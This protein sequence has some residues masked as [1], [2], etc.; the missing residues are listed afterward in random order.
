M[1][2]Q[3][4]TKMN[5]LPIDW[6]III[7]FFA[8][9]LTIGLWVSYR[10]SRNTKS[11]FLSGR[12]MPWWLLGISMV[13]TTFS[14][15]T[16]N[17]V[18][19]IVRTNGVS[20][21]WVWWSF[22]LTGMLTVFIYAKLWRKSGVFT[23]LEF[24]ELRYSGKEA[25][26]L[27]VFRALYLGVFFNVI[28]MATVCLA[29]IKIGSVTLGLSPIQTLLVVSLIT[30]IYSSIGGLKGVIITDFF[31]FLIAMAATIF[32]TIKIVNHPKIGGLGKLLTNENVTDKLAFIPDFS[33]SELFWIIF[34]FPITIQWWN[35]WYPGAEPGGGGYIAQRM[36]AAK[37]EKNAI[38]ATLLFNFVHYAIRPWPWILVALASLILF[39]T[40]TDIQT[41]F[42]NIDTSIIGHDLA[43]PAM[44]ILLPSG[45]L[46]L[47][48]TSLIAAFMSTISTHLNWGASYVTH[49]FYKRIIKPTASEKE[50]VNVGR[51]T[52]VVLMGLAILFALLLN[53]ALQAFS[54]LLQIGAGTGLV[55]I[56]R[57]FWYRINAWSEISAMVVSFIMAIYFEII[58]PNIS[59]TPIATDKKFILGIIITT[60]CWV[61]IT[62]LTRPTDTKTLFDFYLKI[63]PKGIGWRKI[64]KLLIA[65]NTIVEEEK[66][67]NIP[68][69]ILCIVL[70]SVSI[71]S[72]LFCV[73]Y[74]IYGKTSIAYIL[75]A[76]T[77]MSS[78]GLYYFWRK[79]KV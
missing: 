19:D 36:L 11:F 66:N 40:L 7:V 42:P 6:I 79:I 30:V 9:S 33:N 56:L 46:G 31:Q 52:S 23:D 32:A 59:S 75:V 71:Y 17:L 2:L 70:G 58:H 41:A 8:I 18:A 62:L 25:T 73:G 60:F 61:V 44:L 67:Y 78:F 39:P 55:F 24:Y 53:N 3:Y 22:L 35:A 74:F 29:A 54:I 76:L 72:F 77:I 45:I 37:D 12:N 10:S 21:N 15:D 65:K 20:G 49:D 34:L 38:W 16:P 64:Q 4:K 57:W 13:A 14:V 69:G 28:I 1:F 43:Y 51:I 5:I 27:R 26:F 68:M 48:L 47:M 63:K 50:L